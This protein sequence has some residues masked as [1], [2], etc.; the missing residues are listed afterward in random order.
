MPIQIRIQI[1]DHVLWMSCLKNKHCSF[2]RRPGG[3]SAIQHVSTLKL[4]LRQQWDEGRFSIG[5]FS[6]KLSISVYAV[7]C[8]ICHGRPDMLHK[9][10]CMVVMAE[11]SCGFGGSLRQGSGDMKAEIN[12]VRGTALL[13]GH[14]PEAAV[15]G[16]P[17]LIIW[18]SQCSTYTRPVVIWTPAAWSVHRV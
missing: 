1:N 11:Q 10:H 6:A 14:R 12:E 13:P 17:T 8:Y 7:V 2:L 3:L 9:L 15:C 16:R 4:W 18:G 5:E